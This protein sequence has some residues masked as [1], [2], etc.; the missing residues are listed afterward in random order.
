MLILHTYGILHFER[1]VPRF[2]T[3]IAFEG[4]RAVR[5]TGQPTL[6]VDEERDPLELALIGL[7]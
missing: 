7:N 3:L 6:A 4:I 2:P 1:R 5:H